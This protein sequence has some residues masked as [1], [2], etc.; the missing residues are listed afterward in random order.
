MN[1]PIRSL[2]CWT[3]CHLVTL[4][5]LLLWAPA[6][7]W[8]RYLPER[9]LFYMYEVADKHSDANRHEDAREIFEEIA[10]R[11][12]EWD[13]P[14]YTY[15]ALWDLAAYEH[16]AGALEDAA[17]L[18]EGA[19]EN[20]REALRRGDEHYQI[21]EWML[22]RNIH[23]INRRTQRLSQALRIHREK[24]EVVRRLVTA[25]TGED[26]TNLFETPIAD[27]ADP[28]I[29]EALGILILEENRYRLMQG[30]TEGLLGSLEQLTER[31]EHITE[32]TPAVEML[33]AE[34]YS[35]QITLLALMGEHSSLR[36][37]VEKQRALNQIERVSYYTDFER[38]RYAFLRFFETGDDLDGALEEAQLGILA[39]ERSAQSRAA[40]YAR[41][42]PIMMLA[43]A[44]RHEEAL[45]L[46]TQLI[47]EAR[48]FGD[49]ILDR[50]NSHA[51]LIFSRSLSKQGHDE[52]FWN[53]LRSVW[54]RGYSAAVPYAYEDYAR[55]H[56][57]TGAVDDAIRYARLG[58]AYSEMFGPIVNTR[59]LETAIDTWL[60]N[61]DSAGE[62]RAIREVPFVV[63][64]ES[65]DHAISVPDL[66]F[67]APFDF[68]QIE[69]I[70]PLSSEESGANFR[71][72][73]SVPVRVE[74]FDPQTKR[75]IA[76]DANGN[77]DFNDVGEVAFRDSRNDGF[78][79]LPS[80]AETGA[81]VLKLFVYPAANPD[82]NEP[83]G[84]P[85]LTITLEIER[86]GEWRTWAS[87]RLV[88]G[89]DSL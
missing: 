50:V 64:Q 20:L 65:R 7:A 34:G 84:N 3:V 61:L 28:E 77:G 10:V 57:N 2:R 22:L 72:R 25:D 88:Y 40:V 55:Y 78:P 47:E 9:A 74:F 16:Q 5:G 42:Y 85:E 26:V 8:E 17:K 24:V 76:V 41:I 53:A 37:P 11:S 75:L 80:E 23:S 27:L 45:T 67:R 62:E 4:S 66:A 68:V 60:E 56:F 86:N 19:L 48:E 87:T 58:L 49:Y 79:E 36:K 33:L 51:S 13:L 54:R 71:V 14:A 83:I 44:G 18:Y 46:F 35:D 6:Q 73:T 89:N 29:L 32:R 70:I 1:I 39:L 43:N 81:P 15:R 38:V 12:Q 63:H 52:K 69:Y 30:E 31:L 21:A 82:P 59:N